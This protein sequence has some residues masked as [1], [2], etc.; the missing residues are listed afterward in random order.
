MPVSVLHIFMLY[1]ASFLPNFFKREISREPKTVKYLY[2]V[3]FFNDDNLF[4]MALKIIDPITKST[5]YMVK[6]A[7]YL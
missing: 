3:L 6:V 5:R 4:F 7:H 1:L 2:L